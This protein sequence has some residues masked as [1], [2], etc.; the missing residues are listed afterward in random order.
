[1][2]ESPIRILLADQH[3]LFREALRTGLESESD[4]QRSTGDPA[5]RG[6]KPY[7]ARDRRCRLRSAMS[8]ASTPAVIPTR[9]ATTSPTS[10]SR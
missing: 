6:P 4:L 9:S 10:A 5:R 3:A 8:H 7:G 1:M 2:G